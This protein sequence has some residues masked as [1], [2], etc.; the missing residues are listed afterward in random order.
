MK[1]AIHQP[2]HL[3][4]L[5]FFH[6]MSMSDIFVLLDNVP[7]SKNDFQNRNRIRT[8]GTEEGWCWLTVPALTKGKFGQKI[9]QVE[10]NNVSAWKKKCWK[11]II[12]NY[13]QS[14]YFQYY[15]SFF[16]D[17]YHA[18]NWSKLVDLN[19]SIIKQLVQFLDMDAELVLSSGLGVSGNGTELL[20]RI[21]QQLSADMYISGKFGKDYLDE[22]K[23]RQQ[24]IHV[25][26]QDC[27]HPK[28]PQVYEPFIPNMSVIDLLF[29]CGDKSKDIIVSSGDSE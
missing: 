1:V 7:Y 13:S 5:G 14:K 25:V 8:R 2:E 15:Q 12:Y 20:I 21:C 3:P 4:W 11:S 9:N 27:Q 28:Y 17:L 18:K 26:Y 22:A 19:V 6:K 24:G 23:F 16:H 10:I 29:N